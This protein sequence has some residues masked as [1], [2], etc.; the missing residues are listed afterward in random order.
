MRSFSVVFALL[1][2]LPQIALG[3]GPAVVNPEIKAF[4]DDLLNKSYT[5][6]D[7]PLSHKEIQEAVDSFYEFLTLPD[8]IRTHIYGRLTKESRRSEYGYIKRENKAKA[9]TEEKSKYDD[10]EFFHYHPQILKE[11]AEWIDKQP[12]V[13]AFLAH[14]DK[15]WHA[16]DKTIKHPL[17]MLDSRYPGLEKKFSEQKPSKHVIRF[18]KYS[19]KEIKGDELA[20]AHF[21]AG[22][23]TLALGES[24][25]GLRIR[26]AKDVLQPVTHKSGKAL[27]FL[28]STF[29]E[30]VKDK[31]FHPAWHDVVRTAEAKNATSRWAVVAFFE[32]PDVLAPSWET[33]HPDAS[34]AKVK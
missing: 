4:E 25:D 24:K 21:D 16:A 27:F 13:K 23:I 1:L 7:F 2:M 26:D 33:T 32:A 11:Y 14:A 31:Y 18:L 9:S 34:K 3:K 12:K 20:K 8:D 17:K 6:V 22:A 19:P 10:K 29:Q 30:Q 28:A 15:V 5:E